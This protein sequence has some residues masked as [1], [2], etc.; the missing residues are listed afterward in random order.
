MSNRVNPVGARHPDLFVKLLAK[1]LPRQLAAD[2]AWHNCVVRLR[3]AACPH[4]DPQRCAAQWSAA[5]GTQTRPLNGVRTR[6]GYREVRLKRPSCGRGTESER[7]RATV[8]RSR[9]NVC[10]TRNGNE[11]FRGAAVA[12][13][14]PV[15]VSTFMADMSRRLAW[16]FRAQICRQAADRVRCCVGCC[17]AGRVSRRFRLVRS[18]RSRSEE[19]ARQRVARS[20]GSLRSTAVL[21]EAAS[22]EYQ[23]CGLGGASHSVALLTK[24]SS[25]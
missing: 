22:D 16:T 13:E 17:E 2:R 11:D 18:L 15:M 21:S 12:V 25:R 10:G 19:V 5:R 1:L 14:H 20:G 7:E 6:K 8:T 9:G 24:P 23:G 4:R 3:L